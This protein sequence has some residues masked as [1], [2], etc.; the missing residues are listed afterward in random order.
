MK[1]LKL[2]LVFF[3]I[4]AITGCA[5]STPKDYRWVN[6]TEKMQRVSGASH[7]VASPVDV[8]WINPPRKKEKINKDD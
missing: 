4:T 6:D 3:V 2:F 1:W 7:T 8:I 5:G